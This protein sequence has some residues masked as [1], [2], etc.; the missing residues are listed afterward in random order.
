M[1]DAYLNIVYL[2]VICVKDGPI[3]ELFETLPSSGKVF[4]IGTDR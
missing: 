4:A 2:K 1:G 3:C